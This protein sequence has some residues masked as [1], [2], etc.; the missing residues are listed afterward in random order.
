[1]AKADESHGKAYKLVNALKKDD[2][3]ITKSMKNPTAVVIT[4]MKMTCLFLDEKPAAEVEEGEKNENEDMKF[5]VH[6][7]KTFLSDWEQ[8][9]DRM[10]DFE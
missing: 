2:F 9:K 7:S 8:F 10:K 3:V 5:F 4:T 6:A 1:M